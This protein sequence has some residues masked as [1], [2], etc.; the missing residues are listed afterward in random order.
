MIAVVIAETLLPVVPAQAV[1]IG[2]VSGL[3]ESGTNG[4]VFVRRESIFSWDSG[5][6]L[7]RRLAAGVIGQYVCI[8]RAC[9]GRPAHPFRP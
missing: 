8:A 4:Q 7:V 5:D 1:P 3:I 9:H 2:P 6:E